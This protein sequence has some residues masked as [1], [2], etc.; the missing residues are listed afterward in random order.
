MISVK[1]ENCAA[2]PFV[3]CLVF[4]YTI[5]SNVNRKVAIQA[6]LVVTLITA[7]AFASYS[8]FNDR[9][10]AAAVVMNLYVYFYLVTNNIAVIFNLLQ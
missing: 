6:D 9:I 5:D 2:R 7:S 10:E 3:A 4:A 1:F 8:V